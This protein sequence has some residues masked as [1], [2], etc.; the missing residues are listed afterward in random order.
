[1]TLMTLPTSIRSMLTRCGALWKSR[2]ENQIGANNWTACSE[3]RP[4]LP[5][6]ALVRGRVVR[7]ILRA[8]RAL[9]LKLWQSPP[10]N[11]SEDGEVSD[12]DIEGQILLRRMIAAGLSICEPD[13]MAALA[14]KAKSKASARRNVSPR[15]PL[16]QPLNNNSE[17]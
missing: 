8:G 11:L 10:C 1:M 4:F 17:R 14:A 2:G 15:P 6:R 3:G 13:P 16:S 9:R 12:C 5:A 7:R